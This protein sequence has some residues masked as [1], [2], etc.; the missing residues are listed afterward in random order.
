[1]DTLG[2]LAKTFGLTARVGAILALGALV[3]AVLR[4]KNV[5]PLASIDKSETPDAKLR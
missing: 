1:M 3:V 5:E 4:G 2:F